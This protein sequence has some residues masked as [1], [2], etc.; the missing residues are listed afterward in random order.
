VRRR[1]RDG[2]VA[3]VGGGVAPGQRPDG[4]D[5]AAVVL[6]VVV[7]VGDVVL[8]GVDVLGRDLDPPVVGAHVLGGRR[9][10]QPPA[11]GE[12]A[13]GGV[14]LGQVGVVA[15]APRLDDLQDPGAVGPG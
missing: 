15:P 10:R 4:G 9:A 5:H 11:V 6:E 14:D 13:P 2:R 3:D 1:V 7:G 12:A 8:A